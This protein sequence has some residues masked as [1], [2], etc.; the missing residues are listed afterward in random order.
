MTLNHY[1]SILLGGLTLVGSILSAQEPRRVP[2][3]S[4][5]FY[6]FN[7]TLLPIPGKPISI[8]SSVEFN[9]ISSA[10]KTIT[11]HGEED[12]ARNSEGRIYRHIHGFMRTDSAQ[13]S[14]PEEID[15]IDAAAGSQT[16]CWPTTKSCFI[17]PYDPGG[18]SCTSLTMRD[19]AQISWSNL[20]EYTLG[21]ITVTRTRETCKQK[22]G[23]SAVDFWHNSELQLDLHVASYNPPQVGIPTIDHRITDISRSEPDPTIFQVPNGYT[24]DRQQ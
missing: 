4:E 16:A 19:Q 8:K 6:V 24:L 15:L 9:Q 7:I 22:G 14:P 23:S 5:K 13:P 18:E 17:F 2:S 11:A 21:G 3:D 20:G 1:A 10:G 12:L